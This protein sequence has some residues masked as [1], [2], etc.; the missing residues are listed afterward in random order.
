MGFLETIDKKDGMVIEDIFLSTHSILETAIMELSMIAV[1]LPVSGNKKHTAMKPPSRRQQSFV[2]AAVA[3]TFHR[4]H[5]P[6][7]IKK[8]LSVIVQ[9]IKARTEG[10][11]PSRCNL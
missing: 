5:L 10:L 2:A 8:P 6:A 3:G 11:G 9:V 1:P 4:P 7:G